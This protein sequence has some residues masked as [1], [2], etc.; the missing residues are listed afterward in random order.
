MAMF[1][2]YSSFNSH[3]KIVHILVIAC[4]HFEQL[5]YENRICFAMI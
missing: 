3:F 4:S 2:F 1:M 5:L